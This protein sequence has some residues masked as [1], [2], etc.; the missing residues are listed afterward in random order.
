MPSQ[1]NSTNARASASAF[2][3]LQRYYSIIP[4]HLVIE[5]MAVDQ[6]G[7]FLSQG[8]QLLARLAIEVEAQQRICAGRYERSP[9]RK[10]Y[11]DDHREHIWESRVGEILLRMPKLL[12]GGLF[13][14]LSGATSPSGEGLDG[15]GADGLCAW[16]EYAESSL[17]A[18]SS[19]AD[20]DQQEQSLG[21]LQGAGR[22]AH[23]AAEWSAP[24]THAGLEQMGAR[25]GG[26]S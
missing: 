18:A 9:E 24:R 17:P 26:T 22:A 7:D 19:G 13:P 20:R 12:E 8:T 21:H 2:A 4:L 1:P 3:C 11:R 16:G 25:T 14:Q 10:G 6:D 15:R 5:S 23:R